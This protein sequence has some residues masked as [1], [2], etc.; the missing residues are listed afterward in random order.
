MISAIQVYQC[1][2]D[3]IEQSDSD[4]LM[5]FRLLKEIHIYQDDPDSKTLFKYIN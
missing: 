5:R 3:L 2:A 1:N 4:W